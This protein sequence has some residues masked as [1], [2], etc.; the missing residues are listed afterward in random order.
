[1]DVEEDPSS[2]FVDYTNETDWERFISALEDTFLQWGLGDLGTLPDAITRDKF[3][4]LAFHH[5]HYLVRLHREDEVFPP[6]PMKHTDKTAH[7]TPTLL[8]VADN[9]LDLTSP[10]E[11]MHRFFGCDTYIVLYRYHLLAYNDTE[12][13]ITMETAVGIREEDAYVILSSLMVAL[14][15][16]NCTLPAFL[17]VGDIEQNRYM[18]AAVPGLHSTISTHFET[19]VVSEVPLA[20]HCVTGLLDI[21]RHKLHVP[22]TSTSDTFSAFSVSVVYH[23]DWHAPVVPPEAS[24]IEWRQ[25][26]DLN[27]AHHPIW[28]YMN[29]GPDKSPLLS[30]S[31]QTGWTSLKEGMYV[32]N[33]VHSTLNPMEAPTFFLTSLLH[34]PEDTPPMASTLRELL[35]NLHEARSLGRGVLVYDVANA[36]PPSPKKS[37]SRYQSSVPAARAAAVIGEAIGS[38]VG[39]S[40][41]AIPS[42]I[43][44][45]IADNPLDGESWCLPPTGLQH[46]IVVGQLASRLAVLMMNIESVNLQCTMWV[47]F[48]RALRDNWINLEMLPHVGVGR[49]GM[50]NPSEVDPLDGISMPNP[51]FHFNLLHQKIQLL[52]LCIV[53][54]VRMPHSRRQSHTDDAD[55]E[56][57]DSLQEIPPQGVLKPLE[58]HFLL[59]HPTQG[60]N[61]PVTQDPV[62]VTEDVAKEQQDIL[63]K[64]GVSA[65]STLLRQKIQSTSM[66]SDMQA[67]KAANPHG[68]LADFI[69][70]YSPRDWTEHQLTSE[71]VDMKTNFPQGHLSSRMSSEHDAN[72]WQL[73][74]QE[75]QPVPA[76]RQKALFDEGNEAE[77]VF[78]YL[79]TL[80]PATLLY[81][82]AVA[83]IS[84]MSV[85]WTHMDDWLAA[86]PAFVDARQTFQIKCNKAIAALDDAAVDEIKHTEEHKVLQV[87]ADDACDKLVAAL[88]ELETTTAA[89]A[90]IRHVLPHVSPLLIND[91]VVTKRPVLVTHADRVAITDVVW[92]HKDPTGPLH[93][94]PVEREY[95][96]R[97][98][99]PRPFVEFV[100]GSGD[101][102]SISRFYAN[103]SAGEVRYAVALTDTEF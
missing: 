81:H 13:T 83:T 15:N 5:G 103:F 71:P 65:E 66:L 68:C 31:L 20:Q 101:L 85:F 23:Y 53:R 40:K 7:F 57:Y 100:D 33:A 18:G 26:V 22:V 27:H 8:D 37:P 72:P 44:S 9:R 45:L 99:A 29:W 93:R 79:E 76:D 30:L 61:V 98:D 38:W 74:W 90:S 50:L 56:F 47:E 64:L 60:L 39:S 94:Y 77:K 69:R 10:P 96:L 46:A 42:M 4:V 88:A 51:D 92:K 35:S 49:D 3:K 78:H 41:D 67:F 1:M 25:G 95:V 11:T 54:R 19:S 87:L 16:C 2:R 82:M 21:F 32:D 34:Q 28:K 84:N 97:Y 75:A 63:A 17:A 86:F 58:G 52:N 55:D 14:G 62:P 6:P 80:S 36:P 43:A 70:W 24:P 89:L 12:E 91:M 59:H 102:T 48:V 73:M